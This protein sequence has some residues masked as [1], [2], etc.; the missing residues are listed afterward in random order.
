MV[1]SSA[2]LNVI[3]IVIVISFAY[4]A[5]GVRDDWSGHLVLKIEKKSSATLGSADHIEKAFAAGA[6]AS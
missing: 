2:N 6:I 1:A 4:F 5:R 3:L